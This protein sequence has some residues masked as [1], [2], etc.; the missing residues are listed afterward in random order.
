V[1]CQSWVGCL[2]LHLALGVLQV[3]VHDQVLGLLLWAAGL[4]AQQEPEGPGTGGLVAPL[5]QVQVGVQ[6]VAVLPPAW[7][8]PCLV[9][10]QMLTWA[11]PRSVPSL[12]CHG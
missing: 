2:R 5:V 1:H 12:A 11:G 10:V 6:E 7:H 8:P 3:K 9:L 4:Q